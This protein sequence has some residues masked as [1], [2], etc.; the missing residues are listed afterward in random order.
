MGKLRQL[1]INLLNNAVKFTGV[2]NG[3]EALGAFE[4]ETPS[5]IRMDMRMPVMVGYE[6]VRQIRHRSGGQKDPIVAITASAFRDQ[7]PKILAAG[8]DDMVVKPFQ[9]HE[10]FEVMARTL[11][12]EYVYAEPEDTAT[13]I[14]S[15]KLTAAMLADLPPGLLQDPDKTTLVANRDEPQG[16]I[17]NMAESVN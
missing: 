15:T 2:V 5:F 12:V 3:K 16:C 14:D 6:A 11:G 17:N 13:P 10:V 4:K 9:E 8:C 7:Q 1:L